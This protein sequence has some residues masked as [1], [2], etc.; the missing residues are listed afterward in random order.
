MIFPK[1]GPSSKV[2]RDTQLAFEIVVLIL[3][4][5]NLAMLWDLLKIGEVSIFFLLFSAS[6]VLEQFLINK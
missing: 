2:S 5:R 4:F 6:L 1:N 3:F